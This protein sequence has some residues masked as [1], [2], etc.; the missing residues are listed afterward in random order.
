MIL[1]LFTYF[2]LPMQE[3]IGQKEVELGR[4]SAIVI[5]RR[6]LMYARIFVQSGSTTKST[7]QVGW[8]RLSG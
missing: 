2:W 5:R 1:H 3:R 4:V 8:L 7:R 6:Q